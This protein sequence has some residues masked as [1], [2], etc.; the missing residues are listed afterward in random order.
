MNK[1]VLTI[2][3]LIAVSMTAY[4]NDSFDP[5]RDYQGKNVMAYLGERVMVMPTENVDGMDL[6]ELSLHECYYRHFKEIWF[7]PDMPLSTTVGYHFNPAWRVNKVISLIDIDRTAPEEL[8]G[9]IFDIFDIEQYDPATYDNL[10][11]LKMVN[12]YDENDKCIYLYNSAHSK[13]CYYEDYPFLTKKHLLWLIDK[14][15]GKTITL[16]TKVV[17]DGTRFYQRIVDKDFNR[18]EF[19]NEYETFYVE[20]L[21]I[22]NNDGLLYL[23]MSKDGET[24]YCVIR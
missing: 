16:S 15:V 3:I 1:R 18:I 4:C 17:Y 23:K 10:W 14:Y 8:R 2:F 7:T 9:K 12:I 6:Y 24:Y 5:S 19:Q 13:I 22:N 11:L 21:Y 20:K